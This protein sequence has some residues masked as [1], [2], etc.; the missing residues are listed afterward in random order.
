MNIVL[1]RRIA[2]QLIF[3]LID[4]IL[5]ARGFDAEMLFLPQRDVSARD[6]LRGGR[7]PIEVVDRLVAAFDGDAIML[8]TGEAVDSGGER[9]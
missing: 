5:E 7:V 8:L 4:E 6:L 2:E 1:R 9:V 3:A